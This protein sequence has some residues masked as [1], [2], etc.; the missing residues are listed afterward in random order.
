MKD[1]STWSSMSSEAAG[2]AQ[3]SFVFRPS[4]DV[5]HVM[6]FVHQQRTRALFFGTIT[7]SFLFK[8]RTGLHICDSLCLHVSDLG[9]IRG[10]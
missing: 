2:A 6:F 9:V 7:L 10:D 3:T 1:H 8:K 5:L 4:E